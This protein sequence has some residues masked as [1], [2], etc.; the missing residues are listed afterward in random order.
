MIPFFMGRFL[1]SR[2]IF[3][4]SKL[5]VWEYFEFYSNTT[6]KKKRFHPYRVY[7]YKLETCITPFTY[8]GLTALDF[9]DLAITLGDTTN[10]SWF[11]SDTPIWY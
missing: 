6:Y 3:D 4:K 1:S 11:Y 9:F 5:I 7:P 2:W 8:L 10:S